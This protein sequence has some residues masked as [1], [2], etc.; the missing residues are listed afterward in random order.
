MIGD[1]KGGSR[2]RIIF[3]PSGKIISQCPRCLKYHDQ[4]NLQ[5]YFEITNN[6]NDCL[7]SSQLKDLSKK[8]GIPQSQ[9]Y[10]FL[11]SKGALRYKHLG[12]SHNQRG[13]IG[14]L[15]K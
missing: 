14:V 4:F 12:S 2:E 3:Q 11:E 6:K 13:F 5:K 15:F 8:I 1:E 10:S 9:I 7:L